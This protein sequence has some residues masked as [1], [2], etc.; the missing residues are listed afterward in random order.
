MLK[1]LTAGVMMMAA[2]VAPATA[3]NAA[4]SPVPSQ[5][6]KVSV[7]SVNGSGCPPGSAT[8]TV[9]PDNETFT[10]VYSKYTAQAGVGTRPTDFRQNC[11]LALNVRVPQGYTY[12]IAGAEYRGFGHLEPGAFGYQAANYYFQ[13]EA[14]STLIQHNINGPLDGLWQS[15]DQVGI[16]ALTYLRCGAQRYL[17]VNTELRVATGSS[18]RWTTTSFIS[19]DS[20]DVS[21][22][23]VYH[24][25]WKRC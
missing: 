12:A 16:A 8:V 11:Q 9:S 19:M 2:M 18:N 20:T 14:H 23:T 21:L 17:N 25:S 15:N 24:V 6:M 3:A 1:A 13:G 7:V 10:V 5:N 22:N 4:P